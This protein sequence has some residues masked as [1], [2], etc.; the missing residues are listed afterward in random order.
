MRCSHRDWACRGPRCSHLPGAGMAF[1]P[2][3]PDPALDPELALALFVAPVLLDAAYDTSLRDL[4]Q[5]WLPVGGLVLGAVALT[6]FAVT[7]VARCLE[8]SFPWAVALGAIVAL[9]DAAAAAAMLRQVRLPGGVILGIM[10]AR[11]FLATIGRMRDETAAVV[12][13]FL[14]TFGVG[15]WP[16][17]S[18]CPP[19]LT[20]VAFAITLGRFAPERMGARRRRASYAV[21]DVVVFVLNVLAFI[22]I[23]LQLRGIME[24]L[25]NNIGWSIGF[26]LAVLVV[27]VVIRVVWV[28]SYYAASRWRRMPCA[29]TVVAMKRGRAAT[30]LTPPNSSA[31]GTTVAADS[32]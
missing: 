25:G 12:L 13:S 24:R 29:W 2:W 15:Y 6:V 31:A 8:P 11:I 9:P 26:A 18:T 17:P 1:I 14:S 10:L 3:T 28:M 27:T 4:R 32:V 7:V 20:L 19:Y 5:S 16:T 30:A 22:L 21:W 23:G